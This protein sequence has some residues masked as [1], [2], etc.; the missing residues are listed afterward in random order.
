MTVASTVSR[1]GPY[2]GAGTVGPFTIG[3][4]FLDSSH[5]AVVR[6]DAL[7]VETPLILSTDFT[8]VGAG[9]LAGGTLTLTVALAAGYTLTIQRNVPL[10]QLLDYTQSDSFP[11]E[12]HEQGL[13]KLTM[14]VQQVDTKATGALRVP[15]LAGV[16]LLPSAA[17]RAGTILGFDAFGNPAPVAIQAPGTFTYGQTVIDPF[18][19]NG[20]QTVFTLSANPGAQS[21]LEVIV[22]GVEQ[23][24]DV[25]FVWIS[26]TTL[27]F[28]AAPPAVAIRVKYT[29]SLP[30]GTSDASVVA[31]NPLVL[32]PANSTGGVL[33]TVLAKQANYVAVTD[34]AFGGVMNDSSAGARTANSAALAAA[35]LVSKWVTIP[36]GTFWLASNT[37]IP[38]GLLLCGA[39]R[40]ITFVKGD[41]D[42]FKLTNPAF[43]IPEFRDLSI[44]N[45]VTRGKLFRSDIT[46]DIGRVAFVNV[47]FGKSTHHIATAGVVVN[48]EWRGCYFNDAS[49]TS[50]LLFGAWVCSE[51]S[52]YTWFN[53]SAGLVVRGGSSAS[54]VSVNCTYEQ[55]GGNAVILDAG[56]GDITGWTFV[57][58]HFESNGA[59]AGWAF[60]DVL[61]MT[62]GVRRLRGISFVG[63]G[64]FAPVASTQAVSVQITAGGGGNIDFV[65][66]T[67]GFVA[68]GSVPLVTDM[69]A[70]T[71]DKSC[72]LAFVS[73]PPSVQR[74]IQTRYDNSLCFLGSRRVAGIEVG[75]SAVVATL[76]VPAGTRDWR[77]TVSGNSYNGVVATNVALNVSYMS[78][79][80]ANVRALTDVNHSSGSNQGFAVTYNAFTGVITVSNKAAMT[81]NQSGE[82]FA[83]FFA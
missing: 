15:E 41:G 62:S 30:M 11:A 80:T 29:R 78:G 38:P 76:T 51:Y 37:E 10:T 55:N 64:I 61:L 8:V 66:F 18:T 70:V 57:N 79:T 69:T 83:E 75:S 9:N 17:G 67:A 81:N 44:Q 48:W 58:P 56:G 26:G 50:R 21:N 35:A 60:A 24:G 45:D 22:G 28:T 52:C 14:Q 39:G 3:F 71:I 12:S 1:S 19:G 43:G 53:A 2:A 42:L 46:D 65:T 47:D 68:Q 36:R 5:L 63:G 27:T 54:C 49:V 25:D 59:N 72:Y 34:K 4:Y 32:Y 40:Q 82:V 74:P 73:V 23:Y 7:G 33:Q 77:V 6:T 16:P 20:A 13:D 31:Y